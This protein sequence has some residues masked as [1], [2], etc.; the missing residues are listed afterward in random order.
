VSLA[1]LLLAGVLTAADRPSAWQLYQEGQAAEKKGHMAEAYLLYSQ[2]AAL[3]PNNREYWVRS[4]TVRSRAAL[5]AKPVPNPELLKEVP[6]LPPEEQFPSVTAKDLA[7]AR[8]PLPPSELDGQAGTKSF[9]MRADSKKLFEDVAHAFGLDCVFDGDYQASQAIRF[10]LADVDY[11]EALHGLE[12]ATSS[13]LVPLSSKLFLV[14][15]D[16]PQK[17]AEVEPVVAVEVQLSPSTDPKDF[18]TLVTAVQQA[19]AIEKVAFD[20]QNNIVVL[21]GPLSKV[22][23]ARALLE[24]LMYPKAQVAVDLEF[25]E[26]S[27]NDMVS[28]GI[29]FP[30]A[31]QLIALSH[32][33][34]N[35]ITV[36]SSVA[37]L[38]AFGGGS[39][40]FGIGIMNPSLVAKMSKASGDVLLKTQLLGMDGQPASMHVGDKY[41]ILT[42]GYFGQGTSATTSGSTGTGTGTGTSGTGVGTLQLGQTSESW[43]YTSGGV[44]PQAASVTVTSTNGAIAYTATA[45]SSSPWL[46][47]NNTTSA[48]GTLPT[49]LTISPGAGLT[50]LGTGSYLG[51][52]QVSGS[53]GSVAYVTVTLEVN[54]GAQNLTVSPSTISLA[55]GAGGLS[56]QQT[57][58]VTSITGGTLSASVIGSGLSL[59]GTQTTVGANTPATLTVL[60]NP[61]GLSAQTYSGILSVTVGAVTVETAVTFSVTSSGS[62]QLSQTSIPWTY[63]S[64]GSLPQATNVTVSSTSGTTSFTATASSANSWLLVSGAITTSGTLPATLVISPASSLADLGTGTYPGTVQLNA[65]DGS[66]SYINVTLTVNGGTATGLTVSP[67]PISLNASLQG[68][69]VQQAITV[70]SANAG[71]LSASVSGSGLSLSTPSSTVEAD[72]STTFTLYAN[73]S[74]LSANTYIGSLSVTVGDVT[75]TVPVTFSVGAVSSGSNGTSVY[76]PVP[77]FNFEDL[78]LTLKVTPSVHDLNEV[79]LDIEAEFKVLT[80][81]ALNGIPVIANR[82]VKTKARLKE[83]EWAAISGLLNPEDARTVSGLAGMARIPYLGLLTSTHTR[84]RSDDQVL[85]L[86]RPRLVSPPPGQHVTHE[87]RLGSETRPLTP[88]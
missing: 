53:D 57:V 12:L 3:E 81:Q 86:M 54:G 51:T 2:A 83:G 18:T 35:A 82:S 9:R 71:T 13:F 56:V 62:L 30:S 1:C 40:L 70:T 66:I 69:T 10:E 52:V 4:Q 79:T 63:T 67:N 7:D 25:L 11:R 19:L 46:V 48:S 45:T 88:L 87:I 24:D 29:D 75:Q 20:T 28:Y 64:G 33:L 60:G 76:T 49:T 42:S 72:V 55:S 5:E 8:R 43:T 50:A 32:V 26:V 73:P 74:N 78:G 37:G 68:S 80:G 16:T 36:P 77:S 39:S 47:V 6:V 34:N 15:N 84:N 61:T 31:F 38:L 59:S 41:P 44:S 85:V 21:R 27:R 22:L 23:P 17:R 14:V 58:T 65:A